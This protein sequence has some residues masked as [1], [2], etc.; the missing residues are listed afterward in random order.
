MEPNERKP[1][2]FDRIFTLPVLRLFQPFFNA[3]REGLLYLFFGGLTTLVSWA[4]FYLF[5]Q[6]LLWNEHP[7]NLLSWVLAVL[8]A[9]FTNR[10]CVFHDKTSGAVSFFLQL[11]RFAASRVTSLAVEEAILFVFVTLLSFPAFP[12][13]IADSVAVV[14]LNYVFSKWFVFTGRKK[15]KEP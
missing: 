6:I 9:F 3:H 11:L 4:S 14:L 7:A 10:S 15:D 1:D 5:S 12:V 13:K 2:F 8:F